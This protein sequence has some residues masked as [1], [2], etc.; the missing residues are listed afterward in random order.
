[1]EW[2]LGARRNTRPSSMFYDERR[3]NLLRELM[4]AQY[5]QKD[6]STFLGFLWSFLNPLLL[7]LILFIF[8]SSQ[9]GAGVEHYGVYLL[10]GLVQYTHFSNATGSSLR[11]LQASRELTA[12]TVFPKELIVLGMVASLSI[13]FVVS[14]AVTLLIAL[15]TGV[16]PR[17]AWLWV[18]VS[19]VVQMA[20]VCWV[21]IGLAGLY[22]FARDIDHV[23][24]VL[25]RILFF[26]TPIFYE[27]ELV[28]DGLARRLVGLNPLYWVI[29]LTR[30][31]VLQG[32]GPS[33][34]A[35]AGF[36]AVN[37]TLLWGVLF[38]FRRLEPEFAE[39]V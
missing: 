16:E 11:A 4:L 2:I 1:L 7:L 9:L 30:N 39:N 18:P 3:R 23:Y 29:E 12:E 22:P 35:L 28:G 36:V 34:V 15:F 31:A 5:K 21:S 26:A 13:E 32:T 19:I 8:F 10:L 25:L 6:Q 33:P 27:V 38:V 37:L 24:Q 17:V 14:M 20:L